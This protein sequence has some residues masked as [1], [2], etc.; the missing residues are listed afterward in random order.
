MDTADFEAGRKIEC[1]VA[2]FWGELSH[3]EK[4]FDPRKAWPQYAS[5]IVR[6]QPLPCGHYPAEQVPDDVYE[7]LATSSSACAAYSSSVKPTLMVTCQ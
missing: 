4:F 5:N 6:M 7:E 1:P 2:V 3:T